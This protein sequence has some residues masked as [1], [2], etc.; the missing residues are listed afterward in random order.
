VQVLLPNM[1]VY[2]VDAALENGKI[3]F[4]RV[5]RDANSVLVSDIF[6]RL[7]VYLIMLYA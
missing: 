1:M 2:T 3:S 7:M 5:C 6:F 4:D